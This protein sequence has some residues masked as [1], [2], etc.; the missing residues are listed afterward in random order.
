MTRR[1]RLDSSAASTRSR[2]HL[3]C[4]HNTQRTSITASFWGLRVPPRRPHTCAH[5]PYCS[6]TSL[7]VHYM[8]HVYT[9]VTSFPTYLPD[10]TPPISHRIPLHT[11]RSVILFDRLYTHLAMYCLAATKHSC[12]A[13]VLSDAPNSLCSNSLGR[14]S[15]RRIVVDARGFFH[16]ARLAREVTWYILGHKSRKES[17]LS[18]GR[19]GRRGCYLFTRRIVLQYIYGWQVYWDVTRLIEGQWGINIYFISFMN[20]SHSSITTHITSSTPT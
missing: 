3:S 5:T 17:T 16:S 15:E 8:D 10:C 19:V 1:T 4:D 6:F 20:S 11:Q 9:R 12:P 14:T 2:D 18:G 7:V 13:H